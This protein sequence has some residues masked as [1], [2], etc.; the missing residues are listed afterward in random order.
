MLGVVGAL[1][2]SL[3]PKVSWACPGSQDKECAIAATSALDAVMSTQQQMVQQTDAVSL[4]SATPVAMAAPVTSLYEISG[5]TAMPQTVAQKNTLRFSGYHATQI[6]ALGPLAQ[7]ALEKTGNVTK[8]EAYIYTAQTTVSGTSAAPVGI[9]GCVLK[10][11]I[12]TQPSD[13]RYTVRAATRKATKEGDVVLIV[14]GFVWVGGTSTDPKTGVTITSSGTWYGPASTST[15]AD[16]TAKQ[17][18]TLIP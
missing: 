15:V 7:Y 13:H 18:D 16:H 5:A 10:F 11:P 14:G 12:S 6:G 4:Q 3:L 2:A 9:Q 8:E 17:P 1:V